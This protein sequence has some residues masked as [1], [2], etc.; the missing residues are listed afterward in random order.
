MGDVR[1][2]TLY[3][4]TNCGAFL[5]AYALG[6]VLQSIAGRQVKFIDTG[7]RSIKQRRNAKLRYAVKHLQLP[8]IPFTLRKANEYERAYAS[9]DSEAMRSIYPD[10]DILV[11]GSDEI[12]NVSRKVISSYP[13]LWGQGMTGGRR[14]AYAPSANGADFKAYDGLE[15]FR[16]SLQSFSMLSARDHDTARDV[17]ALVGRHVEVVCDPTLLLDADAYRKLRRSVEVPNEYLLVYS[18]YRKGFS[19]EEIES[20][21][22]YAREK[23]MSVVSADNYLP[24]C[25]QCFPCG[26]YGFLGLLDKA[27]YVV[28]DTFHGTLFSVIYRKQL[29][30]Y[31]RNRK[32]LNLQSQLGITDRNC[33]DGDSLRECLER[34]VRYDEVERNIQRLSASSRAFLEH[35]LG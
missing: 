16:S 26:P 32:T 24:W 13:A 1:I 4:S 25:D 12:W 28:T 21:R 17:E 27:S 8:L 15:S 2:V 10:D 30:S 6:T 31:A 29:V 22:E 14:I 9:L 11:F 7:A 34:E 35:S 19:S 3:N 18:S 33:H 5:Q 20:V 23:G